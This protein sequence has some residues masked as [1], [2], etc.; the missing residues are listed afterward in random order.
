MN[1]YFQDLD[2]TRYNMKNFFEDQLLDGYCGHST[3][4]VS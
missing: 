2:S 4:L 3:Y 1:L